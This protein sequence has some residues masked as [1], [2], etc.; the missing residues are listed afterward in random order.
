MNEV[1]AEYVVT[2]LFN[3]LNGLTTSFAPGG[4]SSVHAQTASVKSVQIL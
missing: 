4:R 3:T 1:A 2:T